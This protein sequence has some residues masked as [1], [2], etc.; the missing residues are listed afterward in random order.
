MFRNRQSTKGALL[1]E[2]LIATMILAVG[3]V[4]ALRV[5]AGSLSASGRL[6]K[7]E[8]VHQILNGQLFGW[9]LDPTAF[10]PNTA[11]LPQDS[12]KTKMTSQVSIRNLQ[13]AAEEEDQ[14]SQKTQNAPSVRGG[15]ARNVEFYEADFRV[16]DSRQKPFFQHLFYLSQYGKQ[17]N[18]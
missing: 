18:S 5:F 14:D 4:S 8:Q 15:V 16:T 7:T 10:D 6:V 11:A 9:L 3:V 1:I 12:K 17:K 13:P 2:A